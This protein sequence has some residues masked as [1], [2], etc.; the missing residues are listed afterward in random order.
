MT[1]VIPTFYFTSAGANISGD[2]KNPSV[3]IPQGTLFACGITFAVYLVLCMLTL[4]LP[5]T[6]PY[7][8][9]SFPDYMV[10]ITSSTFR[11]LVSIP[12]LTFPFCLLTS[13][14]HFLFLHLLKRTAAK[15]LQLPSGQLQSAFHWDKE[16]TWIYPSPLLLPPVGHQCCT[17]PHHGGSVCSHT[18]SCSLQPHWSLTSPPSPRKGP[19]VQWVRSHTTIEL[20]PIPLQ[21][22]V[23]YY[24]RISFHVN[25]G[26]SSIPLQGQV[27]YCLRISHCR[28]EPHTT[29]LWCVFTGGVL[30]PF[31][32]AFGRNKEPI[33]AVLFSWALVQ[34]QWWL[35]NRLI[36]K[37]IWEWDY[38]LLLCYI[39]CVRT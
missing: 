18:V 5:L 30:H 27:P 35:E 8:L 11:P 34:V 33:P 37:P 3:S 7:H 9:V 26:L 29:C 28:T 19:T 17:S 6:F 32:W 20:S 39:F 15:Q 16:C 1:T 23:P 36:P 22:Q 4:N 25:I 2:L 10:L 24:L 21:G 13:T 38:C 12:D 31:T 14:S